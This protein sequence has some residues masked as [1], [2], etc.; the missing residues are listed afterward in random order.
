[1]QDLYNRL[2]IDGIDPWLDE[3]NL[4][5]GQNRDNE[6][7]EAV[8]SSDAVIVCLSSGV[9]STTG[10]IHK[11]ILYA[12]D[13]ADEQPEGEIFLIPAKLEECNIPRRLSRWQPVNLQ[14]E[15]GYERLIQSLQL[16]FPK[17]NR[18]N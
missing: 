11:H 12:L 13:I 17:L 8:R 14:D 1:V 9:E 10:Q 16:K 2:R 4:L 5:P 7:Q 15:E 6:I 3:K 18:S